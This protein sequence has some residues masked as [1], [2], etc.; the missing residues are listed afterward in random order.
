MKKV[1]LAALTALALCSYSYAQDDDEYEDDSPRAAAVES[2]SESS[3]GSFSTNS[4][5]K[6]EKGDAFMGISIDLLGF[7]DNGRNELQRFA[8][9]F[10]LTPELELDVHLGLNIIGDVEGENAQGNKVDGNEGGGQFS[11][12]AG[13]D[14]FLPLGVLPLSVGGDLIFTHNGEDNNELDITPMLGIRAEII[15]NFCIN[16]KVGFDFNYHWWTEGD[17][18]W[19]QVHFGFATRVNFIWFF[20]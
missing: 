8:L 10:K 11:L 14:Y 5:V 17:V 18:D 16:G 13:V 1:F 3:S 7:L 6:S 9:I 12:G 19:D 4:S 15:K 20:I 2:S